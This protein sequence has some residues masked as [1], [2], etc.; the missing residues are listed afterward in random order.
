MGP[1]RSSGSAARESRSRGSAFLPPVPSGTAA[2]SD[3]TSR[4]ERNPRR[5]APPGRRRDLPRVPAPDRRPERS[6]GPDRRPGSWPPAAR[7]GLLPP[8]DRRWRGSGLQ[9]ARKYGHVPISAVG[10]DYLTLRA[11]KRLPLPVVTGGRIQRTSRTVSRREIF[12]PVTARGLF[13]LVRNQPV[14]RELALRLP[15]RDVRRRQRQV[16]AAQVVVGQF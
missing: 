6:E 10:A 2:Q 11:P 4:L 15:E 1:R 9:Q 5:T 8:H 12:E 13:S 7:E 16:G 14:R 3:S